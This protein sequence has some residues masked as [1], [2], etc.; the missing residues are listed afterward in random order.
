MCSNKTSYQ[1]LLGF[2][3]GFGTFVGGDLVT[4]GVSG[5]IVGSLFVLFCCFSIIFFSISISFSF[6]DFSESDGSKDDDGLVQEDDEQAQEDDEQGVLFV[7]AAFVAMV[8]VKRL[9]VNTVAGIIN[10]CPF[11]NIKKTSQN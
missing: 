7:S 11:F 1:T 6:D 9:N 3:E 5:L 2:V 8:N 4:L 10:F